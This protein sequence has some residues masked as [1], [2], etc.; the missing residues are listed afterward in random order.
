MNTQKIRILLTALEEG[1]LTK[2]GNLLGYTQSGASWIIKTFEEELGIPLLIKT[3]SGVEAT[4]ESEELLP[5]FR[6]IINSEDTLMQQ[7]DEFKGLHRG[8]L[9]IGSFISTSMHWIPKVISHFQTNYPE[10]VIQV[11]ECGHNDMVKGLIDGT[12]DV[13]FMSDPRNSEIEFIPVIEDPIVA[14]FSEKYDFS[15]YDYISVNDL[16]NVPVLMTKAD[17]DRDTRKVFEESGFEP[18]IRYTSQD[19]FAVLSMVKAGLG[20]AVLPELV[21]EGFPDSFDYRIIEP[22]TYRSLGIG[23]R[24]GADLSPLVKFLIKYIKDN[25]R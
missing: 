3:N 5:V 24:H 13:A 2:A 8:T 19:D 7:I 15:S 17:Y 14:A 23:I 4:A 18:E 1:S 11:T 20:V 21:L 6:S 22:E 9:R 16:K 25:I 10:V 12:M